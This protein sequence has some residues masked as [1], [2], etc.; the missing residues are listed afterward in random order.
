M[1][2][3]IYTTQNRNSPSRTAEAVEYVILTREYCN[4]NEI[5]RHTTCLTSGKSTMPP[6]FSKNNNDII[7]M[8]IIM[9]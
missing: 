2:I 4:E 1:Q 7:T 8:I 6:A 9:N 5:S 3:Y